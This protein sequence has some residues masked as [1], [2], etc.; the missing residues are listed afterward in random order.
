MSE[1]RCDSRGANAWLGCRCESLEKER[2]EPT[3]INLKLKCA[4]AP[5]LV[6][7]ESPAQP[8]QDCLTKAEVLAANGGVFEPGKFE[9]V[10]SDGYTF[11]PLDA[12]A[13]ICGSDKGTMELDN[14]VC[15]GWRL[16][17]GQGR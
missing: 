8:P 4:E 2:T 3:Y 10:W 13:L 11:I 1:C 5:N 14:I 7:F 17:R 15:L 6:S 12:V 16:V 9:Q